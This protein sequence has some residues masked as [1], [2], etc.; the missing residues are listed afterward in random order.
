MYSLKNN[1]LFGLL[2]LASGLSL[3]LCLRPMSVN[4][5]RYLVWK[6]TSSATVQTGT[7]EHHG[8]KIKYVTYGSGEPV[9]LLHGGL[10]NK[11]SWFSQLPWLVAKDRQVIL[12][13]TQGSALLCPDLSANA[14]HR[15]T[16]PWH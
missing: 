15:K 11:L 2:L 6:Y 12:I 3:F 5:L 14:A 4:F 8:A 7:L 13:D 1:S 10:S 9:F 16:L